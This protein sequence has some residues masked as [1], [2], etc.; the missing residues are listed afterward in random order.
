VTSNI[1]IVR[2][3]GTTPRER[4]SATGQSCPDVLK[5][6]DGN[7]LV[8][9]QVRWASTEM[10]QMLDPHDAIIGRDEMAVVVPADAMHAAALDI[11]KTM[12]TAR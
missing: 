9:G 11:T 8:I 12:E 1:H 2:R 7:Y 6:S 3:M 10:G 4:G 5:L